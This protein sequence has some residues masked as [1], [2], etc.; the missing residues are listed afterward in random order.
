MLNGEEWRN[1]G[2]GVT[3]GNGYFEV[4]SHDVVVCLPSEIIIDV[5]PPPSLL[6]T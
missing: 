4:V 5:P 1:V 6:T 2:I 3:D